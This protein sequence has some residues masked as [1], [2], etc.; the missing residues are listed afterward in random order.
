ML[1]TKTHTV[2]VS[3]SI[4]QRLLPWV[5][6]IR[7]VCV[8]GGEVRQTVAIS[9]GHKESGKHRLDWARKCSATAESAKSAAASGG[10]LCV[11]LL[12]PSSLIQPKG[13]PLSDCTGLHQLKIDPSPELIMWD[14]DESCWLASRERT[15]PWKC[16]CWISEE[17][18]FLIRVI[19]SNRAR[20]RSWSCVKNVWN[21][22]W[23]KF[24]RC[25][26]Q[27]ASNKVSI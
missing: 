17:G 4:W 9:K 18:C 10:S 14:F 21:G 6:S 13:G 25:F 5:N 3:S 11:C 23:F 12:P 24:V 16:V 27:E 7:S 8:C 19:E 15:F 26:L 1:H 20:Q 2:G 22:W